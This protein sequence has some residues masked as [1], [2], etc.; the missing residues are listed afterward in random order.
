MRGVKKLCR[1]VKN[2]YN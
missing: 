1:G 2:R